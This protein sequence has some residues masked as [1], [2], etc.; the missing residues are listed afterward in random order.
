MIAGLECL[1]GLPMM[2]TKRK[3]SIFCI[4]R[5][6][7]KG[8]GFAGVYLKDEN[9]W[10][11]VRGKMYQNG[12]FRY[13]HNGREETIGPYNWRNFKGCA[14]V[15]MEEEI[16]QLNI[17]TIQRK[18]NSFPKSKKNGLVGFRERL[19]EFYDE[20]HMTFTTDLPQT[21]IF[22]GDLN[23][24]ADVPANNAMAHLIPIEQDETL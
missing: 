20:P 14:Y 5:P 4:K 17:G 16:A 21:I 9:V 2:M 6:T 19:V 10:I 13:I 24:E 12:R 7:K 8:M 23:I 15:K 22:S 3:R 1:R 11:L 18:K